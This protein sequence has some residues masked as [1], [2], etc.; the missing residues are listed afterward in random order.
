MSSHVPTPDLSD[1]QKGAAGGAG[2]TIVT[3]ATVGLE[4]AASAAGDVLRSIFGGL[5][6]ELGAD[7]SG[8]VA[9]I[10]VALV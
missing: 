3:D 5:P 8:E 4:R 6:W 10:V 2:A 9:G 7:V 1:G